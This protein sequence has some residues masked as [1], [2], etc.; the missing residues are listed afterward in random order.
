MNCY[1][2]L[3]RTFVLVEMNRFLEKFTT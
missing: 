2:T 1:V 3:F